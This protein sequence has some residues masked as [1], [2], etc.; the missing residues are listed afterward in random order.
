VLFVYLLPSFLPSLPH[1][2]QETCVLKKELLQLTGWVQYDLTEPFY[3][4]DATCDLRHHPA[5]M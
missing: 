5:A 1:S 2:S 4:S 3:R